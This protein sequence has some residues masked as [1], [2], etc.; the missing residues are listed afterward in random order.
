MTLP[1]IDQERVK[2]AFKNRILEVTLARKEG[3]KGRV[4]Q[5]EGSK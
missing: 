3:Q 4:V 5:V 2:A 1:G